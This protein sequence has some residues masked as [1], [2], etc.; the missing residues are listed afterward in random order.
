MLQGHVLVLNRS[1]API[2]ITSVKRA[3]CLVF[4]GLAKIVDEQYQVFDFQSW[5][6]VSVAQQEDAIHFT[7]GAVRVPR[8]IILQLYNKLPR[9]DVRF[10]RENVY[11]RDKSTCQYCAKRFSRSKLNI[12]HVVPISQGGETSWENIVCSCLPCNNKKGGRTPAQAGLKLLNEPIKPKY[13]LFMNVSPKKR[14][15]DAWHIY[16]NPIDFAYWNLELK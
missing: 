4:K 5:S 12:D 11:I 7:H 13:S 8:V 1:F 6:E 2:H 3:I 14:L 10:S 9:R 15:L 16:M